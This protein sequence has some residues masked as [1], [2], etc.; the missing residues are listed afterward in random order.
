MT[1]N[2]NFEGVPTSKGWRSTTQIPASWWFCR[3][4]I[5][6]CCVPGEPFTKLRQLFF[7]STLGLQRVN[8][9]THWP[10]LRSPKSLNLT[11]KGRGEGETVLFGEIWCVFLQRCECRRKHSPRPT[12]KNTHKGARIELGW[13]G[14]KNISLKW[15]LRFLRILFTTELLIF[16]KLKIWKQISYHVAAD[17]YV[18]WWSY[19][20]SA[21][22]PQWMDYLM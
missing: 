2:D 11:R 12:R 8:V 10:A 14:L 9:R 20:Y 22:I 6:F 18:P 1:F 7:W 3:H 19:E 15:K 16:W 5:S 13:T 4:R 21:L 17:P